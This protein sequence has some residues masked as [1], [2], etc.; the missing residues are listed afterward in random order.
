MTILAAMMGCAFLIVLASVGFGIQETVKGEILNQESITEISL[1]GEEP[2]TSED[3]EFIQNI[4][5]VN[6]VLNRQEISGSIRTTFEDREAESIGTIVNMEAQSK[7]PTNLIE[8][9]LPENANEIVVGYHYAQK[10]LN[11]SD[12]KIIEQ[13]SKEATEEGS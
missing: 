10:L 2:L 9:R 3:E 8:G 7:L 11:E 6:V 12:K 1:W 4:D 13:K 5:H